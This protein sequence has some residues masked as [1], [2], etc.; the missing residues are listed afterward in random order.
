MT[1]N[2]L[3]SGP[4]EPAAVQTARWLRQPIAFMES[5]RRRYGDAFSVTFLTFERPLVM[6]CDPNV[7]RAIYSEPLNEPNPNRTRALLPI[8]GPRSVLLL[9]GEEHLSYRRLMLPHFHGKQVQAYESIIS[10]A[11]EADIQRWPLDR[12]F[13]LRPHMQRVTLAVILRA[14]FGVTDPRRREQLSALLP[15]LLQSTP[16]MKDIL[17]ELAARKLNRRPPTGRLGDVLAQI[18]QILLSEIAARRQDPALGE[19]QDILSTLILA[20]FED[21]SEMSDGDLRDQLVTLLLA[22]HET[23]ATAL[24]WTF[25]LLLRNPAALDRLTAEVAADDG[26][27]YLRAVISES[28]RLRP[29]VPVSG[30]RLTN[31]LRSDTLTLP[32][33]TDVTP[34]I[35]LTHTNPSLY[36][37]PM[38]F[39]PERFLEAK[40][41]TYGWIPFGGGVR[42]CLGVAFAELEMRVVIKAVLRQRLLM[43]ASR[44]PERAIFRDVTLSP[45]KGTVV[46]AP[47]R[48]IPAGLS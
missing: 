26:D 3:P 30:R 11:I 20:R 39:R 43:S 29:V 18:D 10:E 24:A 22:G 7:V 33:G 2:L 27:T 44:K 37:D 36:P 25:E 9:T 23:T 45:R 21:G 38:T 1:A 41:T 14:V 48:Q 32:A 12:A 5:C 34:A 8:M 46:R 47:R 31:E 6:V 4:S 13:A 35:W 17:R 42:R 19:R 16:R 15:S 40:P 28:L